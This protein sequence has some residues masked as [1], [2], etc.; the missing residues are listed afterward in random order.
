MTEA[1]IEERAERRMDRLDREYLA[2]GL[3]E[4]EYQGAVD[5]IDREV[6]LLLQAARRSV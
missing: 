5:A 6:N 2:G 1:Q 4:L 3:T